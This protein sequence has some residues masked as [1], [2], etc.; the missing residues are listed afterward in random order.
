MPRR[1]RATARVV[2]VGLVALVPG[3]LLAGAAPAAG[4]QATDTTLPYTCRFPSGEQPVDVR[5]SAT[6]PDVGRVG[7]PI[8]PSE[9]TVK[10]TISRAA[11]ADLTNLGAASVAGTVRL[12]TVVAHNRS[13]TEAPWSGLA[14]PQTPIPDS[15]GS[16]LTASGG[17]PPVTVSKPGE[18]TVTAAGLVLELTPTKADGSATDPAKL[19]VA[20]TLE[21]D[22]N[23]TLATIPVPGTTTPTTPGQPGST[24]G[25]AEDGTVT[26]GPTPDQSKSG[27][28]AAADDPCRVETPTDAPGKAK[29]GGFSNVNKLNASARLEPGL[30]HLTFDRI[31]IDICEGVFHTYLTGQF[32][33]HGKPQLPPSRATFVSFGFMPMAATMEL[34]AVEPTKIHAREKIGSLEY[35][36]TAR[37]KMSLRVYDV[38]VNG[39]PLNVGPRC[40]TARPFD[41]VLT[42]SSSTDPPYGVVEGGPLTGTVTIPPFTGCGVGEELD[43]L[44]TAT[45]S[46]SGNHLK[47][48][49]SVICSVSDPEYC[50]PKGWPEGEPPDP[51]LLR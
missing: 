47:M 35:T 6:F 33:Y 24:P 49:Q 3:M 37:T 46:G 25:P 18:V 34:T 13:S 20:C 7:R 50:G 11:L 2:A 4:E 16:T 28:R 27:P 15:G 26:V 31:V 30:M 14:I 42:G 17:A 40:R 23:A 22:Q 39:T 38:T 5:V 1:P 41:V 19:S 45:V 9:V 43:P 8:R 12:T 44:V 32:D 29:I 51:D 36:A 48:T 10:T 21:E